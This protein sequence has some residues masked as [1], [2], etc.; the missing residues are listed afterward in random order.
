MNVMRVQLVQY[1]SPKFS[2]MNLNAMVFGLHGVV[3]IILKLYALLYGIV[4]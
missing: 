1:T 4:S 3:A 2:V